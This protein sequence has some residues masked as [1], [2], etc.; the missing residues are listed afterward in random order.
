[1]ADAIARDHSALLQAAAASSAAGATVCLIRLGHNRGSWQ[2]PAL[3]STA[4]GT[5]LSW[6]YVTNI[7]LDLPFL[8]PDV[9][10]PLEFAL[11]LALNA[12]STGA[13]VRKGMVLQ[14]RM[15]RR[16]PLP[17][18]HTHD[19]F[20]PSR[21]HTLAWHRDRGTDQLGHLQQQAFPSGNPSCDALHRRGCDGGRAVSHRFHPR[22]RRWAA[23]GRQ[24]GADDQT[25]SRGRNPKRFCLAR[26]VASRQTEIRGSRGCQ[27]CLAAAKACPAAS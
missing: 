11:K 16:L 26:R 21:A 4:G 19:T 22:R 8:L 12:I 7:E 2:A 15:V 18:V 24:A 10:G 14:N 3:H 27:E 13:Q 23:T 6:S 5:G 17:F 1:M 20:A 25:T 9:E